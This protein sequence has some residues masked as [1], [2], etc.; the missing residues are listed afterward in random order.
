M[1]RTKL[2]ETEKQI[3]RD[4]EAD[5]FKLVLTPVRRKLL[6]NIAE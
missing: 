3:L 5:E 2:D 1:S 6:Q 4:Y